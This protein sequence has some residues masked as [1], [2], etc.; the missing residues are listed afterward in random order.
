MSEAALPRA[1]PAGV[2]LRL[3]TIDDAE[4]LAEAYTRNRVHLEPW[5]P[6][7]TSDFFTVPVQRRTLAQQLNSHAAGSLLPLVL[8]TPREI[9]GRVTLSG[10][11]RGVFQSA[12]LGYWIDSSFEGR[13]VMTAALRSVIRYSRDELG[14]HRLEAQT[15]LHNGASQRVLAKVGFTEIGMAPQYLRIAGTWQDH[16]LFQLLLE[17]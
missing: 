17:D 2:S 13:G 10:I 11:T 12:A 9:I 4:P 15:L 3:A 14:L 7:R 16:R 6:Q 1:L 5:D 8:T